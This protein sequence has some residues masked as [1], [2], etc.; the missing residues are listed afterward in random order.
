MI[1][2][3]RRPGVHAVDGDLDLIAGQLEQPALHRARRDRVVDDQHPRRL[4]RRLGARSASAS[5]ARRRRRSGPAGRSTSTS[6][7]PP[8][9]PGGGDVANPVQRRLEVLDQHLAVAEHLV[10]EQRRRARPPAV[11]I[12]HARRSVACAAGSRR[13]SESAPQGS[14][15]P[16]CSIISRPPDR[17]PARRRPRARRCPAAAGSAGPPA[18]TSR[19]RKVAIVAGIDQPDRRPGARAAV[20]LDAAA[21][22]LDL[23][24]DD[25]QAEP[26]PGDV[27]DHEARAQAGA[28]QQRERLL[29]GSRAPRSARAWPRPGRARGRCRGRRRPRSARAGRVRAAS[30]SR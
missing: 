17:R 11:T 23:L 3:Q 15:S 12:A 7:P 13:T 20:E 4:G 9:R 1:G 21:E 30:A 29:V 27:G 5:R 22:P 14:S 2:L 25:R 28:E 24:L 26:V 10:D 6:S 19:P 16:S 8:S 18:R